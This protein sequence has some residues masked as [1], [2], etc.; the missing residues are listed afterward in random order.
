MRWWWLL[1]VWLGTACAG[2]VRVWRDVEGRELK[3]EMLGVEAGDVVV[4]LGNGLR[5]T[6]AFQRLSEVDQAWVESW[7]ESLDAE[8]A[9][10]SPYW[11]Q[12]VS[13][14]PVK[15]KSGKAAEGR[16]V[17]FSENYE[18]DCDGKLSP[19]VIQAFAR[20]AEA[21]R[22]LMG[23]LP[24]PLPVATGPGGKHYARVL[25][26]METYL[27]A[28]APKNSKAWFV[29]EFAGR[30]LALVMPYESL[31][32]DVFGGERSN[33]VAYDDTMMIHVLANQVMADWSGII[34]MWL[35]VG[36]GEY[37]ARTPY[38]SGTFR[39]DARDRAAAVRERLRTYEHVSQDASVFNPAERVSEPGDWF[40][41][42]E[43]LMKNE[44]SARELSMRSLV[45]R[46]QFYV[47]SMLL[48]TYYLHYDGSGEARRLRVYLDRLGEAA[49]YFKRGR[50]R[51][52][53]RCRW[54]RCRIRRPMMSGQ[55]WHFFCLVS[56]A[57]KRWKRRL[58]WPTRRSGSGYG[59]D[60]LV[61]DGHE[62]EVDDHV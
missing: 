51:G 10:P 20:T 54:Q 4:A 24:V 56:G 14:P 42:P 29:P 16:T 13:Q 31:G 25:G 22:R 26:S 12:R 2:E 33:G 36:L 32:T 27:K 1:G 8:Q 7:E 48:V 58:L 3:A 52:G 5:R 15:V 37:V 57:T 6:L 53:C 46:H 60:Q 28:G 55:R 41:S 59:S 40:L 18:F 62:G 23:E 34:P 17:F 43:L 35:E 21:T 11:P 39:L 9:L 19:G 45:E 47:T 61:A 44:P 38:S 50:V 30:R 49:G